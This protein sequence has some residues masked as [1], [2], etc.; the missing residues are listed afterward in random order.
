MSVYQFEN[1]FKHRLGTQSLVSANMKKPP[2]ECIQ[3]HELEKVK[4]AGLNACSLGS[5]IRT[6]S[7]SQV[8]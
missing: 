3:T 1:I 7:A 2:A 8:L 5:A 6:L 4:K